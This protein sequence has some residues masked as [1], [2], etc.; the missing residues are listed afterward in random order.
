MTQLIHGFALEREQAIPELSATARIYRHAKTGGRLLSIISPDENK[1]FG[2]ALRTPPRDSTGLPHILEHS[3]LCGSRKY[4]VKE[5]FVE[6]IKGS[7]NTFLNALTFPDK[8]CYPVASANLQDFY[9]LVDVYL[10]AVFF[11]RLTENTLKQEGWHY[12]V[13]APGAPLAYKGVVFNEMKGVYSSPDSLLA[14]YSQRALFPDTC[15]GLDSGGDPERIPDLTF[16]QFMDF[17]TRLYHPSNAYAFFAGDDDPEKRLELLDAY[18]S[19][20][21]APAPGQPDS[22]VALQPS[23]AAPRRSVHF[24]AA[25]GAMEELDDADDAPE[26]PAGARAMC[27]VNFL[28]PEA[29]DPDL[30]LALDVLEHVLIGLPSS[31]LRKALVDSGLG[32]DLTGGGLE[33]DLR[34]MA[35]SVGLKGLA[36]G[37]DGEAEAAADKVE[38]LV[39]ATLRA[40]AEPSDET[41]LHPDDIRAALNS[42]EFDLRENNTG[43]YPRGLVVFFEALSTW[44]YEGDPLAHLPFEGPLARLKARLAA[45]E[46]VFEGLIRTLFLD[47][48]H[49]ALVILLPDPGLGARR[50]AAEQARL[51]AVADSLAPADLERLAQETSELRALQEAPDAPEDLAKIPRLTLADLPRENARIPHERV[52]LPGTGATAF[53]H[54]LPTSGVVYLDLAL[55]LAGVPDDLVPLAPILGRTLLEMG[56]R[57]SS[58][59][60]LSRSIAMTTGGLWAQTFVSSV[61]DKGPDHAAQRL[62]LRGKATAA[63]LP[64][65]LDLMGEVLL[66]ADFS[67]TERLGRIILEAKA[68]REQRLI[69]AG[70]TLAATRLKA[71][72]GVAQAMSE[73]MSG[74]SGLNFVRELAGRMDTAP[75]G[76]V[77]DLH[78]LLAHLLSR[79]GLL[80][81]LTADAKAIGDALPRVGALA[82]SLPDL[83]ITPAA[84]AIPVLPLREG[85]CLPAQVNYVAAGGNARALGLEPGATASVAAKFLR[86]GYLWERVRVQGGA[87]GASCAY[88]RLSGNLVF[89]SYRDPN[90]GRTLDAYAGVGPYLASL[91]LDPSELEKSVI[92]SIGD[93]DHYMLP[94]AKGFTALARELTGEDTDYRQAAREAVL[95]T[96]GKDFA[97]FGQAVSAVMKD[98]PVVIAGGREALEKSGLGLSLTKVL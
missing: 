29:T 8:T 75:D 97:A 67:D 11:P 14:E 96:S 61:R 7:L 52:D 91:D 27:T 26:S 34:Q 20:F 17:H 58:F 62:F 48:P 69:P 92:G 53:V 72:F 79:R 12:D 5:P 56:T 46:K 70:H 24:Y 57:R 2:V 77:A 55:D 86:A 94:D 90:L 44:L 38:G 80:V 85:L 35:F 23:F 93:M 13:E 28:L 78:R 51:K 54:D 37:K 63:N 95:A 31:P 40:L 10:D 22:G 18:F 43:S 45:G 15:Y 73:A 68:R 84:R 33:T 30:S 42:V 19:L 87:Y 59:V 1:V 39:L 82:G 9:N 64:A 81:N 21:E 6:L 88:S 16:E 49:R 83:A 65:L 76:V 74:L 41:G 60:D 71:R 50:E 47:N 66:E 3:V 98:G 36:V 4:P 25:D 32:E 89:A